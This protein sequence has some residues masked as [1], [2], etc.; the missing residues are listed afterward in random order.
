M[1]WHEFWIEVMGWH[2]FW[3][4]VRG[5]HEFWIEVCRDWGD[6]LA[7]REYALCQEGLY[8]AYEV[9]QGLNWHSQRHRFSGL[10]QNTY[11]LF[12]LPVDDDAAACPPYANWLIAGQL[13]VKGEEARCRRGFECGGES[14]QFARRIDNFLGV[15]VDVYFLADLQLIETECK[16]M[17]MGQ[18]AP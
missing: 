11:N 15:T 1:G 16:T 4:V 17:M 18:R 9:A 7:G 6:I 2:E 5:W 12:G 13:V 14:G 8:F 10:A 3:I